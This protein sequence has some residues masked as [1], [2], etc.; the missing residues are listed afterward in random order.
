ME[1]LNNGRKKLQELGRDVS[2]HSNTPLSLQVHEAVVS[3][4]ELPPPK[5]IYVRGAITVEKARKGV[6]LCF[7]GK[8]ILLAI[9]KLFRVTKKDWTMEQV[10]MVNNILMLENFPIYLAMDTP[11]NSRGLPERRFAL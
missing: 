7:K 4:T 11:K 3:E 5:N 9:A 1:A 2:I 10:A 6:C 8:A